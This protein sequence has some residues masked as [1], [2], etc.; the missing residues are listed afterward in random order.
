MLIELVDKRLAEV[1]SAGDYHRLK[2]QAELAFAKIEENASEVVMQNVLD[3]LLIL[4]EVELR[5]LEDRYRER[6]S[7]YAYV[8]SKV[9][10]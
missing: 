3:L 8:S 7:A 2:S 10:G 1:L 6:Y 5:L 9:S 4:H